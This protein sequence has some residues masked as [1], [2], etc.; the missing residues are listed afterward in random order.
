MKIKVGFLAVAILSFI[1]SISFSDPNQLVPQADIISNKQIIDATWSLYVWKVLG[2][3][4]ES[5][6]WTK[7]VE[8]KGNIGEKGNPEPLKNVRAVCLG[9]EEDFYVFFTLR[10]FL[11]PSFPNLHIQGVNDAIHDRN[12]KDFEEDAITK[13]EYIRYGGLSMVYYEDYGGGTSKISSK[14]SGITH[15]DKASPKDYINKDYI[16]SVKKYVR[17]Y[18]TIDNVKYERPNKFI[19]AQE[20]LRFQKETKI[21]IKFVGEHDVALVY[22]PKSLSAKPIHTL[23]IANPTLTVRLALEHN[24][25]LFGYKFILVGQ[26]TIDLIKCYTPDKNLTFPGFQ[27]LLIVAGLALGDDNLRMLKKVDAAL[28]ST[29]SDQIKT[30]RNK[31]QLKTILWDEYGQLAL[32]IATDYKVLLALR[33]KIVPNY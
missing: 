8:E 5:P 9:E 11:D 21:L 2:W 14:F 7:G 23:Q 19:S 24:R 10:S 22:V 26:E 15:F 28:N 12:G 4:Y 3:Q 16:N 18:E 29:I 1:P 31:A 30:A 33:E 27:K 20:H 6:Y 17:N 25:E 13:E 32:S